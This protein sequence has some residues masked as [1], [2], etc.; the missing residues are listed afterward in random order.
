MVD[1]PSTIV[2][3]I[4]RF[5][6]RVWLLPHLLKWLDDRS[7]RLFLV[8][9]GPGTGKSMLLAWLAGE[10]PEPANDER[11]AQLAKF[12][13]LV[14]AAHFCVAASG[15]IS[16]KA[17]ADHIARQLTEKI[18]G[19]G[20]ALAAGLSDRVQISGTVRV[21]GSVQTG[22]VAAGVSIGTL[23]L[24]DLS[25]EVSFNRTVRE[26][27]ERLYEAGFKREIVLLVDALDEAATY[28]GPLTIP[29]LL[30]KLTDLPPSVRILATTRPEPRVRYL[31]PNIKPL[32]LID[33]APPNEDDVRRYAEQQLASIADAKARSELARRIADA[34][35]G[36]FL[37]AHLV[38]RDFVP[39][40]RTD[41]IPALPPLPKGLSGLYQES[42]NRQFGSDRSRW[43]ILGRPVLGLLAV[44]EGEGFTAKQLTRIRGAD[45][46]EPL[47]LVGQYLD[48]IFPDGPFRPF[49]RSFTE[50]L[51]D[52]AAYRIDVSG[53][54]RQVADHYEQQPNGI[55]PWH[56]WDDYGLRYT[57]THL[58]AGADA[59]ERTERHELVERLVRLVTNTDFESLYDQQV[60]DFAARQHDLE[61]AVASAAID[62]D[63][64][65]LPLAIKSAFALVRFR[66]E[67]LQP[68]TL[69]ALAR[70]G[71]VDLA[72]RRLD[73]FPVDEDWK[74]AALLI[75]A[76]LAHPANP[77][78]AQELRAR[79]GPYPRSTPPLP[80]LLERLDAYLGG[81]PAVFEPLP[82]PPPPE[83]ARALVERMGG[84]D[85]DTE[86]LVSRGL[87]PALSGSGFLADQDGP[88]L[89]AYAAQPADAVEDRDQ[90]LLQYLAL[91]ASYN[92]AVYR[93]GSLLALLRAVLRHPED[94]WLE[95]MLPRVAETAFAGSQDDF[96]G[97]LSTAVL[98]W[99][100]RAGQDEAT[101]A[102]EN[103][104]QAM[105]KDVDDLVARGARDVWGRH[106]RRLGAMAEALTLLSGRVADAEALFELAVAIPY[107]FAGFG[108]GACLT[109][110]ES[111]SIVG[112]DRSRIDQA[113]TQALQ[114]AHNIQDPSFCARATA[115]VKAMVERWWGQGRL[116]R[117]ALRRLLAN[118]EE[119]EF[120]ALHVVGETHEY[121]RVQDAFESSVDLRSADTLRSLALVF[122]RPLP[123]FQRL[124]PGHDPDDILPAGMIVNAPDPGM[125]PRLAARF[126]AEIL[127]DQAALS[128]DG[129]QQIQALVPAAA[130]DTTCLDAVL[131]RL[132]IAAALVR[133]AD[134]AILDELSRIVESLGPDEL[135]DEAPTVRLP[136]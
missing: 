53:M 23:D 132:V 101:R 95:Q 134:V 124:N 93:N 67:R 40:L 66:N 64:R 33:D 100:T 115:R 34:A 119:A 16:P 57:A 130:I 70:A 49:H 15:N 2:Q 106:S 110:A 82:A 42:L 19:F 78:G 68:A 108:Y 87:D 28:T 105:L 36:V 50:F 112:L 54:H 104:H 27:L 133:P 113:L 127:A 11:H 45:V 22:A 51:R 111:A 20:D 102:L 29:Q 109:M 136:A 123:D 103:Q 116:D 99:R 73:L 38:L 61:R 35:D 79:V 7:Q 6:G 88:L 24:A 10:G 3:N 60:G 75:I 107:G 47:D 4:S 126:A 121:R 135:D 69:F 96:Q 48:G 90:F 91:H 26:P 43:F 5:T 44:A 86:L 56:R 55:A 72:A 74:Q 30:T 85:R 131:A 14:G 65:S 46:A 17:F 98:A 18:P 83:V 37:Y 114:A 59:S 41:A 13:D 8:T 125:A 84:S 122:Q 120:A 31:F 21:R 63:P 94:V 80:A 71:D 97:S 128:E 81:W 39:E 52:S 12:R 25:E 76:W 117:S 118:P 89:V 129:V 58:A 77:A 32:D 62:P 1:L 9:G 92:Y